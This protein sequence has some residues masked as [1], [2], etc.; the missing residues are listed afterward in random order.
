MLPRRDEPARITDFR[1]PASP[2]SNLPAQPT[3]LIGR[4]QD[5]EALCSLLR[6]PDVRLVT[7]TGPAGIGKTRLA[8]EAAGQLLANVADGAWFVDLAPICDPALVVSTLARTLGVREAGDQPLSERLKHELCDKQLLLVLDNFEQVLESA[9][10]AAELLAV[11]PRLRVLVTSRAPLHLRWEHRFPVSPLALPD[12]GHLPDLNALARVAAVALFIDRAQAVRPDFRLTEENARAVA[13]ICA[14]LDGLPLAIELAAACG[15]ML[16]PQALLV[17]LA[18]H[19]PLRDEGA[20]DLPMRHQTLWAAITWS[21]NLLTPA[22]QRLLRRL[23]VLVDGWILEAAEA[24][25]AGDGLEASQVLSLLA[26]LVDQSLVTVQEEHGEARY[27]LLE[28]VRE[29]AAEKLEAPGESATLRDRHRDWY[30]ALAEWG[31]T[32]IFGPDQVLWL[33]RLEREHGNFVAALEWSRTEAR[34]AA[35]GLQLAAALRAF[36]FIRGYLSEGRRWLETFLTLVGPDGAPA[37]LRAAA[38]SGLGSIRRTQGDYESARMALE[39]SLRLR[40]SLGNVDDTLIAL[41]QVALLALHVGDLP[42]AWSLY[43]EG[44]VLAQESKSKYVDMFLTGLAAV[45]LAQGDLAAARA[46]SEECLRIARSKGNQRDI[47]HSLWYLGRVEHRDGRDAAARALFDH[48]LAIWQELGERRGIADTLDELVK[49]AVAQGRPERAARLCGAADALR[50]AIGATRYA[51]MRDEYE[52]ACAAARAAL[53]EAT[54]ASARAEGQAMMLDRRLRTPSPPTSRGRPSWPRR[55]YRHSYG[56]P[57]VSP[58][59][60]ARS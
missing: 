13:Q 52:G 8:V 6:C 18:Q 39:E 56:H 2:P 23:A 37:S 55:V 11:C 20:R 31:L 25:C 38:L 46:L 12:P 14:H 53:S 48:V 41:N 42:T 43:A 28:T 19:V 57:P 51:Y 17:R 4:Q 10:T 34:G 60:N 54:F 47:A 26:R 24:V 15:D 7:L 27:R 45:A 22:E 36:W 21:Y 29:Y 49:V 50:E 40:R 44:L 58:G 33:E 3:P 32:E 1:A 16:P 5:L 35:V 59:A 30:L 9:P